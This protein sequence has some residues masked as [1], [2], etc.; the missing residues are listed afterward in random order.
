MVEGKP[1]D[2]N[3]SKFHA[4]LTR[5]DQTTTSGEKVTIQENTIKSE[6][7]VK[8]IGIQ[9]DYELNFALHISAYRPNQVNFGIHSLKFIGPQ[10]WNCLLNEPK[11]VDSLNTF[12]RLIAQ[13]DG[14][15]CNCNACRFA[16]NKAQ[17]LKNIYLFYLNSCIHRF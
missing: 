12:K 7:S 17:P 10:I 4:L 3:P 14:P 9:L 15:M 2:A 8:V 5:K 13:W 16:L 11:S 6:D 1:Y